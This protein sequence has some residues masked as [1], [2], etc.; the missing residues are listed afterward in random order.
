MTKTRFTDIV[1]I[2][3]ELII[4]DDVLFEVGRELR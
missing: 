3:G 1:K 4:C 2:E